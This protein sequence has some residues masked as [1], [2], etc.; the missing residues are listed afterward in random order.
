MPI[1]CPT[2]LASDAHDYQTQINKVS[3]FASRIQID[4]TDGV[5]AKSPTIALEQVWV[6][7]GLRADLHLMYKTPA[8]FLDEA[9]KLKPHMIIVHAEADGN[10]IKIADKIHKAEIKVGVAILPKTSTHTI[11]PSLS[12]I[13]HVLIFSGDLGKFGGVADLDLLKK[14]VQ[15][16]EWKEDLEFGWDGGINESNAKQLVMGGVRVLNVGGY[17][18]NSPTPKQNYDKLVNLT[19]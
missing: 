7:E 6:P 8:D 10:F 16:K 15:L 3:S 13:D 5:F 4:L 17:I 9:I 2:V 14:I 18:Q 12:V 11:K 19:A 1:I